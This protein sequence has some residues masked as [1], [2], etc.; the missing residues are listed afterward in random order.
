MDIPRSLREHASVII[1]GSP[2]GHT[3]DGTFY[4][5]GSTRTFKENM[6]YSLTYQ[7][8][9]HQTAIMTYAPDA[10]SRP[11]RLALWAD[12]NHSRVTLSTPA[13]FR[14]YRP[15]RGL[16]TDME[17]LGEKCAVVMHLPQTHMGLLVWRQ[18][19]LDVSRSIVNILRATKGTLL[20]LAAYT[21][22]LEL[23]IVEAEQAM[24]R[25]LEQ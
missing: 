9:D 25:E 15:R 2:S 17:G 20:T 5:E 1:A 11:S 13:F 22:E 8:K 3:S 24:Q 12:A 14:R 7:T 4:F 10:L 18:D 16:S 21:M 6:F 23:D 19:S